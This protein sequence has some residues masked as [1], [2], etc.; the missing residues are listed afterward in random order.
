MSVGLRHGNKRYRPD[1]H[2]FACG[3]SGRGGCLIF[4]ASLLGKTP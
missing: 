2:S 4:Q 1:L 3:R